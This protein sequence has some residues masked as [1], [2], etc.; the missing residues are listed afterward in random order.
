MICKLHAYLPSTIEMW[1]WL[2][3]PSFRNVRHKVQF[4]T[5]LTVL[6]DNNVEYAIEIDETGWLIWIPGGNIYIGHVD[7][8]ETAYY[9]L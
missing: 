8:G 5:R 1:W 7:F 3:N 6:G 2:Q 4:K 9:D